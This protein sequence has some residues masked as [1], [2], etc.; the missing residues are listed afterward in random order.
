M[1][2]F[3]WLLLTLAAIFNVKGSFSMF[4]FLDELQENGFYDIIS[5]VN[6][7]KGNDIAIDVCETIVQN[8]NCEILVRVFLDPPTPP[9][10]YAPCAPGIECHPPSPYSPSLIGIILRYLDILEANLTPE[11]I[12][13]II[14]KYSELI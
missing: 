12:E 7:Y 1:K 13:N 2:S 5:D 9:P 14:T 3:I 10:Q 11:E 6:K 8:C 4:Q